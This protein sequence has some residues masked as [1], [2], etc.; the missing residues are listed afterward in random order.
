MVSGR[1]GFLRVSLQLV[2]STSAWHHNGPQM[3]WSSGRLSRPGPSRQGLPLSIAMS[4][5]AQPRW[6]EAS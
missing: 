3:F 4:P 2:K 5:C 6:R 1:A